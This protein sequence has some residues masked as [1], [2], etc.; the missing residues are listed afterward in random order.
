VN[1]QHNHILPPNTEQL[2]S[3]SVL[4][5][6]RSRSTASRPLSARGSR[7]A[8]SRLHSITQSQENQAFQ[9]IL[10][11]EL[12][13]SGLNN[14]TPQDQSI[15]KILE[16][17]LSSLNSI[18]NNQVS[19]STKT[20]PLAGNPLPQYQASQPITMDARNALSS[21]RSR[22]QNQIS[23]QNNVPAFAM[24]NNASGF[25]TASTILN[26]INNGIS[27]QSGSTL[28]RNGYPFHT[29][30]STSLGVQ[31]HAIQ[32]KRGRKVHGLG[33]MFNGIDSVGALNTMTTNGVTPPG[34]SGLSNLVN[35]YGVRYPAAATRLSHR[36]NGYGQNGAWIANTFNSLLTQPTYSPTFETQLPYQS[37]NNLQGNAKKSSTPSNGSSHLSFDDVKP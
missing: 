19:R 36:R 29:V 14:L 6:R 32:K 28:E 30:P 15:E 7:S 13:T 34:A 26:G 20:N 5:N 37:N 10:A 11:S 1:S 17:E 25:T 3:L 33:T 9:Q 2:S 12:L 8:I 16:N 31:N 21:L 4:M 23:T 18:V 22:I 24:Q 35:P 27:Q